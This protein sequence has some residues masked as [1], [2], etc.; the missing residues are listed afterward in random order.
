MIAAL[1]IFSVSCS[2]SSSDSSSDSGSD[3]NA[4]TEQAD[5]AA[6]GDVKSQF[7]QICNETAAAIN[8]N[9][10]DAQKIASEAGLKVSDLLKGLS[11]DELK[12]LDSDPDVQKANQAVT[13][14]MAKATASQQDAGEGEEM[15][16]DIQMSEE[17][18]MPEAAAPAEAVPAM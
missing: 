6:E 18:Q 1:A 13:E 15:T 8:A 14:A 5:Q 11:E 3:S 16:E 7:I 4:K 9:P 17:V 2:K 10:A 12:N